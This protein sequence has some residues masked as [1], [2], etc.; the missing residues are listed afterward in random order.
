MVAPNSSARIINQFF[1]GQSLGT[2]MSDLSNDA[3]L[4][5][6][7]RAAVQKKDRVTLRASKQPIR[8]KHVAKHGVAQ[9]GLEPRA[10][11]RHNSSGISDRHQVFDARWEHRKRAGVCAAVDQLLQLGRT[12]NAADEADA[13]ARARV[14]DAEERSEHVLLE[15]RHVELFDCVLSASE[16]FAERERVPL[17]FEEKPEMMFARRFRYAGVFLNYEHAVEFFKQLRG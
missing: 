14:I 7:K 12:T 6:N 8:L 17:A 2:C 10:F 9:L 13:L 11:R 4:W 5:Q 3:A 1:F 15:Q 16:M